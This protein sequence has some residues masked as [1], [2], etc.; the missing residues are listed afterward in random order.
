MTVVRP[1]KFQALV[2][3]HPAD[4]GGPSPKLD[5]APRRMVL[6]GRSVVSGHSQFF[7]VLVSRDGEMPFRHGSP[8]VQ[9]TLRVAGD[10]VADYLDVG[11]HF[12]LWLGEDVADGIVTR[13][14]FV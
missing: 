8:R 3:L 12:N 14:L 2:T 4:D 1:Y 10:D 6:R 7:S 11:S 9:I 13:R 5:E